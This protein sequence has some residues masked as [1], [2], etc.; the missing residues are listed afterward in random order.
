MKNKSSR[1]IYYIV[2]LIVNRICIYNTERQYIV[3]NDNNYLYNS[4]QYNPIEAI[5]SY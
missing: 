5:V 4:Y 2:Q 3:D 1:I